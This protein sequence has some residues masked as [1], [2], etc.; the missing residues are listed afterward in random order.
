[1]YCKT[2]LKRPLQKKTKI[3]FQNRLSLTAGQKNC[4]MLQREHSAILSIF[5]KL[6][7]VIKIVFC[8]FMSGRLSYVLLYIHI[9]PHD[10]KNTLIAKQQPL[11]PRVCKTLKNYKYCIE[12][13]GPNINTPKTINAII[14]TE[15]I[16]TRPPP[17][18]D[19][20][21]AFHQEDMYLLM[22]ILQYKKNTKKNSTTGSRKVRRNRLIKI[23][24]L[25]P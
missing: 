18:N 2:C 5:I 17:W 1:M 13:Q 3:D 24:T 7:N 10:S 16:A 15:L 6:P 22:T 19:F 25:A 20:N 4:R 23:R 12:N 21:V 9:V 8:L 14:N 11:L